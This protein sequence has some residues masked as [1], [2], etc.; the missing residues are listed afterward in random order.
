MNLRRMAVWVLS[1]LASILVGIMFR[2]LQLALYLFVFATFALSLVWFIQGS[3]KTKYPNT[4]TRAIIF[5]AIWIGFLMAGTVTVNKMERPDVIAGTMPTKTGD[6]DIA[7]ALLTLTQ[8]IQ[9]TTPVYPEPPVIEVNEVAVILPHGTQAQLIVKNSGLSPVIVTGEI[10]FLEGNLPF[11]GYGQTFSLPW[12][13]SN[14]ED[15]I[16]MIGRERRLSLAAFGMPSGWWFPF[17]GLLGNKVSLVILSRD[18]LF[19]RIEYGHQLDWPIF[20]W[21]SSPRVKVEVTVMASYLDNMSQNTTVT[22]TYTLG[23]GE[24]I[25]DIYIQIEGEK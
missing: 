16:I 1:Q 12:I 6:I 15:Q 21:D 25:R 10:T 22:R 13:G 19:G 3:L 23:Y 9:T 24:T 17:I 11:D 2:N 8:K 20:H 18:A 14:V 5:G 4:I 7:K